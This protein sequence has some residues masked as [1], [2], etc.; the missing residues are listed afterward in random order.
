MQNTAAVMPGQDATFTFDATA[1]LGIYGGTFAMQ[2]VADKAAGLMPPQWFGSQGNVGLPIAID[3]IMPSN[4][5][6]V[7]V[8]KS[9]DCTIKRGESQQLSFVFKNTGKI[10]WYPDMML[11]QVAPSGRDSHLYATD[12]S[13]F[14]VDYIPMLNTTPVRPGEE[15]TFQ[16]T[17]TP[18]SSCVTGDQ[19][20][21]L[22]ILI[23]FVD[24]W[25]FGSGGQG[26]IH[27]TVTD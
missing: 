11:M 14:S 24:V 19:T 10:S 26:I 5:G 13:W 16:F 8:S 12:G 27:V 9:P 17:A 4:L 1:N 3:Y 23:P 22:L 6:A 25:T 20:F 2:L 15:A 18:D 7:L 21:Q